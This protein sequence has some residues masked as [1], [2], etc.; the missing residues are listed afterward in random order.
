MAV[1]TDPS[2]NTP[3]PGGRPRVLVVDDEPVV[4]SVARVM[5]ERAGFAVEEAGGAEEALDRV[6]SAPA[7]FAA[8]LLDYTLPDRAGTDVLPELHRLSP[9]VR[10][11]LTSGRPEEELPAHGADAYLAKPFTRE[12]LV[13][14]VRALT[15]P[16]G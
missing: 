15:A 13:A 6:R 9:G 3:P 16:G 8:V 7:P 2:T 11:V 12:Q 4:R 1:W 10:V 14:A 5:L